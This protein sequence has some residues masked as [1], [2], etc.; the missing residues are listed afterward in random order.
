MDLAPWMQPLDEK[1]RQAVRAN[2]EAAPELAPRQ[3]EHLRLLFQSP[4]AATEQGRK[5]MA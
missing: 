2:V 3:R 5:A 4:R 1:S